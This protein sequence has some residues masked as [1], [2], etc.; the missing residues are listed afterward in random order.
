MFPRTVKTSLVNMLR[1]EIVRGTFEPGERLRLEDLA[2]RFEVS[3]MPIREALSTLE[4]EGLVTI[5][6][7]RG[8][9]VT[10]F[11]ADEIR[12]IYEMRAVLEELATVKAVPNLTEEDFSRLDALVAE[13]EHPEGQFDMAR[14]SQNNMEFHRVIYDRAR[15]PH[16][17]AQIRDLRYRVQHYLHKHLESTNYSLSGNVEHGRLVE[18]MRA[19]K[20]EEA[21]REMHHHILSTGLKIADLMDAE[22]A[23]RPTTKGQVRRG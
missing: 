19:G 4:S 22:E 11:S 14:F 6:P 9:Q 3:T 15:R 2:Q 10:R 17:A 16:L 18:L 1:D 20:A 12:E 23:T 21:G 13:M 8:A 5:Q 7:H